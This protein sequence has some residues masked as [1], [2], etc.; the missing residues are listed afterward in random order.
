M[1]IGEKVMV[2]LAG[3]EVELTVYRLGK[4]IGSAFPVS[5]CD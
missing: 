1:D 5:K 4:G 2:N 3:Y